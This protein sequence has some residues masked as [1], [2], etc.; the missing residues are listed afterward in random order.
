MVTLTILSIAPPVTAWCSTLTT[1]PPPQAPPVTPS[2][3]VSMSI[4]GGVLSMLTAVLLELSGLSAFSIW[5]VPALVTCLPECPPSLV[6]NKVGMSPPGVPQSTM[7]GSPSLPTTLVTAVT[8]LPE[9]SCPL[10]LDL[11]ESRLEDVLISFGFKFSPNTK[12][13]YDSNL[14]PWL[15]SKKL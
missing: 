5:D 2:K 13:S 9:S 1:G 7:R 12:L 3:H 10:L 6:S 4:N 14:D 11:S 15:V 8:S